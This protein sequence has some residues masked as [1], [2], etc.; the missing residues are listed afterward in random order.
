VVESKHYGT[1]HVN[2]ISLAKLVEIL[3][4]GGEF[5]QIP[6]SVMDKMLEQP[7]A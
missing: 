1:C 4:R 7:T 5:E 6:L 2:K 3:R